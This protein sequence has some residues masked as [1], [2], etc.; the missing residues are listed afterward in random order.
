MILCNYLQC[1]CT[2]SQV[3]T[4]KQIMGL[5]LSMAC[6]IPQRCG[7][8]FPMRE[9]RFSPSRSYIFIQLQKVC[10]C[11]SSMMLVWQTSRFLS[12]QNKLKFLVASGTAQPQVEEIYTSISKTYIKSTSAFLSS[13]SC[14]IFKVMST[15]YRV[16]WLNQVEVGQPY[17][18][19]LLFMLWSIWAI[20]K[21]GGATSCFATGK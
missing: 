2:P 8:A 11:T 17:A 19:I 12:K 14:L 21:S 18:L 16:Y 6:Q 9:H 4:P 15:D 1:C 20:C 7:W 5:S 13:T 10:C 3:S